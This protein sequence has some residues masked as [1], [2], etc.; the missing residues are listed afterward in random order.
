MRTKSAACRQKKGGGKSGLLS[1]VV[2]PGEGCIL[3]R[4]RDIGAGGGVRS[5]L[6]S[7]VVTPGQGCI[8][9]RSRDIGMGG[10]S[11]I[12]LHGLRLMAKP[13]I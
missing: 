7:R 6:Q 12:I 3:I 4:S 5:V 11:R 8:L 13:K 2:T 10:G 1:R 9:I